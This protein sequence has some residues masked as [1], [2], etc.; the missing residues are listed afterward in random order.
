MDNRKSFR[1]LVFEDGYEY[2]RNYVCKTFRGYNEAKRWARLS[3][4]YEDA[5]LLAKEEIEEYGVPIDFVADKLPWWWYKSDDKVKGFATFLKGKF[6]FCNDLLKRRVE[7]DF[8]G[9]S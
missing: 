2:A 9:E 3:S 4:F 8:T 5:Y 6:A 7:V 1:E